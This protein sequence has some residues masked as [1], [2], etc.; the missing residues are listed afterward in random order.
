MVSRVLPILLLIFKVW[1]L[2]DVHKKRRPQYWFFII[3]FV[4]FGDV[5]YFF[6]HKVKDFKLKSLFNA[7]PSLAEVE[8][9]YQTTPSANN[10][11]LY[12]N[13]LF[14]TSRCDDALWHYNAVLEKDGENLE[15][16]YGKSVCLVEKGQL[17]AGIAILQQLTDQNPGYR[18]Y[19]VWMDLANAQWK[20]GQQEDCLN[21]LRKL[22]RMRARTDHQLALAQGLEATGRHEESLQVINKALSEYDHSPSHTQKLYRASAKSL[23]AMQ[24]R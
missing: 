6:L 21:T 18:D 22:V 9:R 3:F 7:P 2:V 5:V 10:Q 16:I 20:H 19:Q 23:R 17:A 24:N 14:D 12:A 11:I 4:P 13:A 15:A 8:Y 1:L